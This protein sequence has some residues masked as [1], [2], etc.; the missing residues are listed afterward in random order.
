MKKKKILYIHGMASHGKDD[1]SKAIKDNMHCKLTSP[2]LS[3][4]Y[5]LSKKIIKNL[6]K[7]DWDLIIGFS[8]G[9]VWVQDSYNKKSNTPLLLVNPIIKRTEVLRTKSRLPD[10]STTPPSVYFIKEKDRKMLKSFFNKEIQIKK[11][12]LAFSIYDQIT[13]YHEMDLEYLGTFESICRLEEPHNI[14]DFRKLLKYIKNI[15]KIPTELPV[16]GDMKPI[17]NIQI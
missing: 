17:I 8:F 6:L 9:T 4:N 14:K 13:D 5:E 2:T 1:L 16:E 12:H 7:K 15:L 3:P 11:R 10:F